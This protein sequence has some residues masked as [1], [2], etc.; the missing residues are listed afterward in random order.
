MNDPCD[1]T[2]YLMNLDP[3][4][5]EKIRLELEQRLKQQQAERAQ[6]PTPASRPRLPPSFHDL[7]AL[8][9]STGLDLSGLI[10]DIKRRR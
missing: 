9:A 8:A 2:A 4:Q 3:A 10:K 5:L 6:C 1:V 7:D